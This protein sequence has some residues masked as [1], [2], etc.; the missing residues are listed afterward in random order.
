[1]AREGRKR[2]LELEALYWELLRSGVGTVEA[3]REAGI[4]R[5]TG[6]RWRHE[7]GGL[8]PARLGERE[9]CGRYLSRSSVS[10]SPL[11]TSAA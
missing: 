6:F 7:T 10:G 5:K 2:R 9:H 1:M 4:G 8:P 3:C 11:S